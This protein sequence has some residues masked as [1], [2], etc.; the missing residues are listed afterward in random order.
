MSRACEVCAAKNLDLLAD[1]EYARTAYRSLT[2]P[3]MTTLLTPD[4]VGPLLFCPSCGSLLDVPNDEDVIRCG[5][6]GTDLD[7][8]GAFEESERY[9][10]HILT[11]FDSIP[12]TQSTTI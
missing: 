7:A 9:Q 5:P 1:D 10:I 6:C 11:T 3:T 8:G 4:K 12:Y 2:T